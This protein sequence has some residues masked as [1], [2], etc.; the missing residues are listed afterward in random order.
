M[1]MR[2]GLL[3]RTTIV[4]VIFQNLNYLYLDYNINLKPVKV[5]SVESVQVPEIAF[6]NGAFLPGH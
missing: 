3:I 1:L 2:N 4:L 5:S 6:A